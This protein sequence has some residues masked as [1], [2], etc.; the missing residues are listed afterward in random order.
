MLDEAARKIAEPEY[1]MWHCE[2]AA[3][4]LGS[5]PGNPATKHHV[6]SA[7]RQA[8]LAATGRSG[9]AYA[10]HGAKA[11]KDARGEDWGRC[12]LVREH[13][14]PVGQIH[15]QVMKAL[16][17]PVIHHTTGEGPPGLLSPDALPGRLRHGDSLLVLGNPRA[18]QIAEIV[19]KW[20]VMAWIS[21]DEDTRLREMKLHDRMPAGWDGC[22]LF[23]RY[24]A[25]GL[26]W[27]KIEENSM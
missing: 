11:A 13:V 6:R 22:D 12:G 27:T 8:T 23:A 14:V 18:W 16:A 4:V 21:K 20:T 15:D 2:V 25:C 10:S 26:E 19:R 7:L 1:F 24:K 5:L 17:S 9:I 3:L